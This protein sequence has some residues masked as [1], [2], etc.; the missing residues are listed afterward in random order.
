M[1]T[2]PPRPGAHSSCQSTE[3]LARGFPRVLALGRWPEPGVN[4]S[5]HRSSPFDFPTLLRERALRK[6]RWDFQDLCRVHG[7]LYSGGVAVELARFALCTVLPSPWR[8]VT[9]ATTTEPLSC[10][11]SVA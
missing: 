11:A 7:S 3:A 8:G 2:E 1:V 4:L 5:I 9:P 10:A 6:L